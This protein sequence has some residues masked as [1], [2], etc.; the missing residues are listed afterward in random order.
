MSWIVH[1]GISNVIFLRLVRSE[2]QG[3]T[4]CDAEGGCYQG[5][6]QGAE[7]GDCIQESEGVDIWQ[8]RQNEL[9]QPKVDD[10]LLQCLA[11]AAVRGI[12]L[13]Y[14][15]RERRRFSVPEFGEHICMDMNEVM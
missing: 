14:G 3:F 5:E 13:C 1:V 4:I 9:C 15:L 12:R 11:V 10:E 8:L 6:T 7:S 2:G